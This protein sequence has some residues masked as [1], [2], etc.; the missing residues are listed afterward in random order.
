METYPLG[1]ASSTTISKEQ[2]D[3]LLWFSHY[4]QLFVASGTAAHQAA[5]SFTISQSLLKLMS[6][7]A[8]QVAQ[9]VKNLSA[10]QET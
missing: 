6:I 7:R 3:L 9:Y 8:G 4:V 2:N 1:T 5:L 10:M